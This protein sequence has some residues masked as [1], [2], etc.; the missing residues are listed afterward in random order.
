MS[1]PRSSFRCRRFQTVRFKPET[2]EENRFMGLVGIGDLS[3]VV[4]FFGV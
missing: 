4:V 1:F 2:T 3:G